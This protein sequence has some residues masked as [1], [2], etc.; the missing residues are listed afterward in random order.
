MIK[1]LLT[2]LGLSIFQIIMLYFLDNS[3]VSSI[4]NNL[5]AAVYYITLWELFMREL[6]EDLFHIN[7]SEKYPMVIKVFIRYK[8]E[9]LKR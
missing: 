2:W 3:F 4:I 8:K 9:K 1:Y 6:T 7:I 5:F